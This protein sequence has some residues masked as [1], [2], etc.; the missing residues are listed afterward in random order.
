M[1][2]VNAY[3]EAFDINDLEERE[4]FVYFVKGLDAELLKIERQENE[5]KAG[6]K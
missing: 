6:T 3:F 4:T 2:D 5:A 1:V